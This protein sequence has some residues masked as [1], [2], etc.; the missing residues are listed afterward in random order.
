MSVAHYPSYSPRLY[1]RARLGILI[2]ALLGLMSFT[3]VRDMA[4]QCRTTDECVT[5]GGGCLTGGGSIFGRKI[6]RCELTVGEWLRIALSEQAAVI[7][8]R[9]GV[10]VSHM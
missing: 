10:P 2:V 7:L 4:G 5:G 8:R 9:F 6:T 3:A 1:R